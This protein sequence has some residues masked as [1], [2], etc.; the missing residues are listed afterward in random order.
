MTF[1]IKD[2]EEKLGY[3][4]DSIPGF[5]GA[6]IAEIK[7]FLLSGEYGVAFETMCAIILDERIVISSDIRLAIQELAI[8]MRIDPIW[9]EK[10]VE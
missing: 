4:L 10:V 3:L 7:Q 8:E 5:S 6:E 1:H 2:I 9:W